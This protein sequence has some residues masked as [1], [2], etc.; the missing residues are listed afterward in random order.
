[1]LVCYIYYKQGETAAKSYRSLCD[2]SGEAEISNRQ[3]RWFQ[4]IQSG[5]ESL[6]DDKHGVEPKI[7]ENEVLRA[8][9]EEVDATKTTRELA[10]QQK[11]KNSNYHVSIT[12]FAQKGSSEGY[13]FP[14]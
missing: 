5:D 10:E 14:S 9:I 12:H 11:Q 13:K 4:R 2:A 3:C 6:E 8:A 7:V 1:M